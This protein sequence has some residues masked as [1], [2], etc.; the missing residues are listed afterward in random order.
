V[1]SAARLEQPEQPQA[2]SPAGVQTGLL[3]WLLALAQAAQLE[4]QLAE[5]KE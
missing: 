3:V 2:E 5:P 1:G 4:V